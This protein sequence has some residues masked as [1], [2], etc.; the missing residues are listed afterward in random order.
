MMQIRLWCLVECECL[1]NL[2]SLVITI[3]RQILRDSMYILLVVIEK[4]KNRGSFHKGM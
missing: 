4:E 1:T 2:R 3:W